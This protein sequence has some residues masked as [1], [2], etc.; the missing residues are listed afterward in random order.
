MS[1]TDEAMEGYCCSRCGTRFIAPH[2]HPVLCKS[3]YQWERSNG[4]KPEESLAIEPEIGLA[5]EDN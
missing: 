1:L 2:G 5:G 4:K 3:C